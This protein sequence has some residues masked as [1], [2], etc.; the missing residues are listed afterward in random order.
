MKMW[1][2]V[3]FLVL[4]MVLL[5]TGTV[6]ADSGE[7][8]VYDWAGLFDAEEINALAAKVSEL[9][10]EMDMGV[11]IV[12]TEEN[13]GSASDFADDFYEDYEIGIGSDYSGA[14]FLIDM[15]N[16]ELWISTEGKMIR[17][18]TD[19]RIDAILDDAIEYAYDG[20]FYDS[21]NVFLT[22]LELYYGEGIPSDQY[23][24]DTET[25]EISVYRSIQWYEVLIALVVSAVVAG[26]AVL[27]V[28]SEYN[29]KDKTSKISA[30]FKL[31]YRKDS[32]FTLN[33][34][35]ADV[36]LGSYVTRSV[37]RSQNNSR[38]GGG[39]GSSS[40]RS[41]TH[42]SGSGRVHGGGGRK[43]R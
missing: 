6:Y 35:L 41:S 17:Y 38:P 20:Y 43:F 33:N 5:C 29:M 26:G 1:K 18:L 3:W 37:I 27:V 19:E 24:Y 10:K 16:G 39:G 36:L 31:S 28:V 14:L 25:G 4:T 9:R 21:A 12:T 30:N 11:A 7:T 40:G 8:W 23:N 32:G 13:G 42:R 34:V 2:K 15:A 22:N